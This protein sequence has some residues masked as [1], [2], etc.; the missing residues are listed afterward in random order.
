VIAGQAVAVTQAGAPCSYTVSP[1]T[2]SVASTAG[3]QAVS[4]T[5]PSGCP[6]TASTTTS[7]LTLSA[8]SGSGTGTVTLTIAANTS[9]TERTGTATVAGQTVTITQAAACTYAVAPA[10]TSVTAAGQTG[11]TIDVTTQAGCAW[12]A[13]TSDTWIAIGTANGA[14]NGKVTFG[15]AT[16]KKSTFPRSGQIL[17]SGKTHTVNQAG[18]TK[19]GSPKNVKVTS[20]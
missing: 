1:T 7:W 2:A 20:S 4:V 8:A 13:T 9:T 5:V 6:W 12:T 15:V 16:L 3:T 17:V 11:L 19:P 10:T 14:G 18:A